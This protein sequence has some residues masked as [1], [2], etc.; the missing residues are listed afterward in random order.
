MLFVV[1]HIS[2]FCVCVCVSLCVR[3]TVFYPVMTICARQ[4][5]G[6]V[7]TGCAS[8]SRTE[9]ESRNYGNLHTHF[10]ALWAFFDRSVYCPRSL[11]D[12]ALRLRGSRLKGLCRSVLTYGIAHTAPIYEKGTHWIAS[13]LV[14]SLHFGE[15]FERAPCTV[16]DKISHE[17]VSVRRQTRRSAVCRR[18][19][20]IYTD[21]RVIP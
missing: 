5:S 21:A 20:K 10:W 16:L 7:V 3:A 12:C 14:A 8:D 4:S 2:S 1:C 11:C 18:I 17:C 6:R 13:P 19:G 9:C 15:T